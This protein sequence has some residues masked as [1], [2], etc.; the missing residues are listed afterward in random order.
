M[1]E[2]KHKSNCCGADCHIDGKAGETNYVCSECGRS[3]DLVKDEEKILKCK[4]CGSEDFYVV[5]EIGY[6]AYVGDDGILQCQ[7]GNC[8]IKLI[9]CRKCD[10]EY[11]E[12]D[13]KEVNFN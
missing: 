5:E 7:N 1:F 3:C 11:S 8:D 9:A 13:F 10:A 4:K 6:K 12:S 2:M